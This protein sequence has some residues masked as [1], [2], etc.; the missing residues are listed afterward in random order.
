MLVN[1]SHT[2]N[3]MAK[4]QLFKRVE[5]WRQATGRDP[6]N[7]SRV[8]RPS[9]IPREPEDAID[10][11]VL[12]MSLMVAAAATNREDLAAEYRRTAHLIERLRIGNGI[13]RVYVGYLQPQEDGS[14]I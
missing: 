10:L 8:K 6:K 12:Y 4:T 9:P 2:A 7:G 1:I 14:G 11:K 5:L 13:D 3:I